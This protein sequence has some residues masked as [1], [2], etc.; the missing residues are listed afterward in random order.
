[1]LKIIKTN[2]IKPTGKTLE[3]TD[4]FPSPG[5]IFENNIALLALYIGARLR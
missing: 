5:T 4:Y 1:M 3:T 2:N